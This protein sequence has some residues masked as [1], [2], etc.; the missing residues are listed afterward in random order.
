MWVFSK[1][2]DVELKRLFLRAF[3][4]LFE[5]LSNKCKSSPAREYIEKFEEIFESISSLFT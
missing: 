2:A 4:N 3:A 5:V 1:I